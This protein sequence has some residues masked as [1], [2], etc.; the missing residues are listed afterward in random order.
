MIFGDC[1]LPL[2]VMLPRVIHVVASIIFHSFPLLDNIMFCGPS[3]FEAIDVFLFP[4]PFCFLP[5]QTGMQ[6]SEDI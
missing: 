5:A 4:S 1:L 2:S 3:A 6:W